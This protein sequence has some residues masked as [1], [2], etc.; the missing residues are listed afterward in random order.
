M[1]QPIEVLWKQIQVYFVSENHL[2]LQ[3]LHQ[4]HIQANHEMTE[5]FARGL[6][7]RIYF[8]LDHSEPVQM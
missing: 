7:P 1:Q 5:F 4:F 6:K 2:L 8:L 3:L